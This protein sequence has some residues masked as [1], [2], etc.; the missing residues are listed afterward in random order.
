MTE[1]TIKLED[2][3]WTILK[4]I[5]KK[6]LTFLM[7]KVVEEYHEELED[8]KLSKQIA[9]SKEIDDLLNNFKF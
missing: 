1:L 8:R 4:Q 9:N 2:K 6:T 7:Y 3:V 5:D